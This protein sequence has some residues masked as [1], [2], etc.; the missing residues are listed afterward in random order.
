MLSEEWVAGGRIDTVID[1]IKN[2]RYADKFNPGLKPIRALGI[3]VDCK[4]K[5]IKEWCLVD[6]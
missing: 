5:A 3:A 6:L 4:A 1:Q 2:R